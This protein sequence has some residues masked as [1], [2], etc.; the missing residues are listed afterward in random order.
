MKTAFLFPGQGSQQ[1]GMGKE[2]YENFPKAKEVYEIVNDA[3]QQKLTNI[4]FHGDEE[5]LRI[6]S[7]TQPAIMATSMAVLKVLQSFANQNIEDLCDV[8]AGHSL[9]EYTALCATDSLT[10]SDT[11][12]ILRVRGNAMQKA[13]PAGVG[14]MY[15]LI[16]VDE[17]IAQQ[18][19]EV[20]SKDGIC[21]IANDNGAG[22]IIL[23]GNA[24]AFEKI[25]ILAKDFQIRKMVKLPVNAPFH[26]SLM[27]E[28]TAVMTKGLSP[29]NF[30]EPKVKI[31]ANYSA[32]IYKSKESIRELL[33]KQ[34]EGRVRWRET[35]AKMYH[36]M[37]IRKFVEI[38]AG[39]VLSNLIKRQYLDVEVHSLQ[40][41]EDIEN[42]LK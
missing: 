36:E 40:K 31:I 22:Q 16:G 41:I 19:C 35:I 9:G 42:Y 38:G 15:A 17:T 23:S 7:N 18:I 29:Y 11:A 21:E 32:D 37:G 20:L 1:V 2:F 30:N 12:K 10:L 3:L 24:K 25:D 26:C 5:K 4:I 28:A 27:R 33:I 6:T 14:M 13:V 39:K 8:A 34:I